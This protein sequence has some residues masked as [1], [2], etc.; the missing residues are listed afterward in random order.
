LNYAWVAPDVPGEQSLDELRNIL[1]LRPNTTLV[2]DSTQ[3]AQAPLAT[4]HDFVVGQQK[5]FQK[6]P[7]VDDLVVGS[8]SEDEGILLLS[9]DSAHPKP[10]TTYEVLE[11][12]DKNNTIRWKASLGTA[13]TSCRLEGCEIGSDESLPLLTKL[14]QALGPVKNVSAPR[15]IHAQRS[16]STTVTATNVTTPLATFE[17]M[18]EV[19]RIISKTPLKDPKGDRRKTRQMV[20]KAFKDKKFTRLLDGAKIPDQNWDD[21]VP[22]A[23]VLDVAPTPGKESELGLRKAFK[24]KIVPAAGPV[25]EFEDQEREWLASADEFTLPL[26]VQGTIPASEAE[27]IKLLLKFVAPDPGVTLPGPF[28]DDHPYPIFKRF[29]YASRKEFF[30]GLTWKPTVDRSN[31]TLQFS[32]V[33]YRYELRM[34]VVKPGTTDELIYNYYP[35]NGSAPTINF[36]ATNQTYQIFGVV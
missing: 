36:D 2:T 30:D 24:N 11:D 33:R 32:G 20:L 12:A 26:K 4:L 27:Q 16:F 1:R 28:K 18:L 14:K 34:P 22:A 17:Y 5:L 19:F 25:T 21:W 13:N 10:P 23:S 7:T 6:H 15:F 31:N 9:V 35:A 8:H 29:H 3:D